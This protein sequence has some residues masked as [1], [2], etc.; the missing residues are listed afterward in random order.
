MTKYRGMLLIMII[1]TTLLQGCAVSPTV[2]LTKISG[3]D[4]VK[5]DEIDT[6]YLR[7]SLI[8]IDKSGTTKNVK[9]KS[10]DSLTITSLIDEHTDFKIGIRRSDTVGTRTN[11]NITKTENTELIKE[12]GV[13]IDDNRIDMINQVGSIIVALAPMAIAAMALDEES[14]LKPDA[15]PQKVNVNMLLEK[16]KVGREAKKG[17]NATNGVTVDFGK[18]PPDAKPIAAFSKPT[19]M[20]GLIYSSCRTAT[21]KL[22]YQD[23]NFQK[24]RIRVVSSV[25]VRFIIAMPDKIV[26]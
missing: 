22:K 12:A 3:P 4:D 14:E 15:L 20:N 9:G 25:I 26:R 24:I 2:R 17:I 16:N 6:F 18:V 19:T 21:V 10:I 13:E 8:M 11:L 5:G 7:K 1:T 23:R